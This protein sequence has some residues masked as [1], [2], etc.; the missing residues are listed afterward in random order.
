MRYVVDHDFHIH[1]EISLCSGD[2]EQTPEDILAY[3]EENGLKTVCLTDHF[4][5]ESVPVI[6]DFD[7]YKTQNFPYIA[8]E[9]PL[10][11]SD[12]VRFLFGCETD[13]DMNFTLGI[14]IANC[15]QFDFILIS[16]THM[17][18]YN[19]VL[20]PADYDLD[21][22]RA[23][24][25]VERLDVVLNMPLPF[26]KVGLA[27]LTCPLIGSFATASEERYLNIL[28]M[29]P[30]SEME[31]VFAKAAK[32]GVG[33][34]LNQSDIKQMQKHPETVMRPYKIA[35]SCGCKFFFG[36]D[37]HHPESLCS[38]PAVFEWAIDALDLKES[39]KFVL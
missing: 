15:D 3:A 9:K 17:H 37:A 8:Q 36:S 26:H 27:H 6:N 12:K 7:Y 21:H 5:D 28:N 20:G 19:F 10:P 18:I 11:Q 33:I 29:I 13:M 2:S 4:W 38:A 22:R 39:D 1:S 16:T 25:W 32:L 23:E 34:E 24:L 35:K 31:R 30:S 14:N